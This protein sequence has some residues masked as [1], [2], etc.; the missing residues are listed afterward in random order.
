MPLSCIKITSFIKMNIMSGRKKIGVILI[1]L[2]YACSGGSGSGDPEPTPEPTPEPVRKEIKM[3]F[4]VQDIARATD[5]T[6]E[7]GDKIGLYVV[8]YDGQQAGNLQNTGNHV[9]NMRFVYNSSWTPDQAI[10]W[11]DD[12]TKADFYAYYPYSASANV[13]GY[14]FNVKA[15]QA[16]VDNYKASDFLWGK[17]SG[18]SPTEQAVNITLN[19]VF[20]CA[21]VKVEPGNG[22]TQ[23]A[24][25][26]A[27][28]QVKFNHIRLAASIDL[29]TGEVEAVNEEQSIILGK[30]DGL[31][32]ALVVPQSISETDLLVVNVNGKDYTLKKGHHFER[33]K[34][35]TFTVKVNKTSNGI[36]VNIGQWDDDGGDYGGVAE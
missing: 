34:R 19:H 31:Y 1:A 3:L 30:N 25:D 16:S 2:L 12:E 13:S 11:K 32:R 26:E 6:F 22:F 28:I 21:Q 24:L 10:Y 20:S 17:T 5:A 7:A 9:N 4:G 8:N 27:T 14:I 23:A 33:N 35:Y 36:N 15:D 29:V 18:V